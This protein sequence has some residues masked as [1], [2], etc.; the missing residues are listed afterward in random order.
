LEIPFSKDGCNLGVGGDIWDGG[1]DID[2]FD[3]ENGTYWVSDSDSGVT[4]AVASAN[5]FNPIT[6]YYGKDYHLNASTE[7]RYL[8]EN[9]TWLYNRLHMPNGT[10]TDGVTPGNITTTLGWNNET[11]NNG[12]SRTYT[13]VFAIN[14][15]KSTSFDAISEAQEFFYIENNIEF[16]ADAGPD[17][18]VS[19]DDLVFFNG[20]GF[21]NPP[22]HKLT[23]N[24]ATDS[25]LH[26]RQ[27]DP[28][29][30][31]GGGWEGSVT[32]WVTFT[33]E[34]PFWIAKK[35][36]HLG[37]GPTGFE[38]TYFWKMHLT[39]N[40]N[41]HFRAGNGYF[42]ADIYDETLGS[43]IVFN[44]LV[45]YGSTYVN[46][47]LE[48]H[49]IY[50]L[51]VHDTVSDNP[52]M[53]NDLDVMFYINETDILLTPDRESIVHY[54]TVN[55][56]S[57]DGDG[58]GV[59][60]ITFYSRGVQ[61]FYTY[62]LSEL[63]HS[64][65]EI[66][67]GELLYAPNPYKTGITPSEY[68]DTICD[69]VFNYTWDFDDH[70]DSDGDGNF[71]NDAD[72]FGKTPT[73]VYVTEG[74]YEVTV[75]IRGPFGLWDTD[76]CFITVID[77]APPNLYINVSSDS[78]DTVLSWDYPLSLGIDHY[79]IYRSNSQ[80]DF[81]FSLVWK[82]TSF[83]KELNEPDPIPLRCM[84]ND[85]DSANLDNVSCYS[86]QYYYTIRAVNILG[87]ISSTSRTVGKWTRTFNS[88]VSTFSLPLEPLDILSTHDLTKD[89]NADY[90]KYINSTTRTWEKHSL[91]DGPSNNVKMILGEGYE[92]KFLNQTKYTF[93]GMPAAMISY[94]DDTGFSGFDY[95]TE[96]ANLTAFVNPEGNVTLVWSRPKSMGINDSYLIYR[97]PRRDGFFKGSA[98]VVATISYGFEFWTDPNIAQPDTQFYYMIMPVNET[99]KRGASSYSIGIW[100]EEYP[101]K[102]D[103]MGIPLKMENDYSSDW[104]CDNIQNCVGIN[105][106]SENYGMWMW[107]TTR[108]PKGAF[109]PDLV[110]TEGYQ[111]ST[112]SSTKF[113]F[114]GI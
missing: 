92:V 36:G 30:P 41:L 58:A 47:F 113:T 78:N 38:Y 15:S 89:M 71:T 35:E 112:A 11:L 102:Y 26:L 114:I 4:F 67:G 39:G 86:E 3:S 87:K 8:F 97:A 59:T 79:L 72:G 25:A 46:R 9:E 10:A 43:F 5:S 64:E 53:P 69:I 51:Y 63:Y 6:H 37:Q 85:T 105:Y 73:H 57:L 107:H 29:G 108:M 16:V 24:Y 65:T 45:D 95:K 2:G 99:G 98:L 52:T 68:N 19:V 27:S 90:I 33:S 91:F 101:D 106:Y 54:V 100:T 60:N 13:F 48:K 83:D 75:K 111:I 14:D 55:P 12:E 80:T 74:I 21:L 94:D 23:V 66:T 18:T 20:S 109:D 104:F 49:H 28:V 1:D 70:V 22:F 93:C 50:R 44:L 61:E 81:N 76:S 110:M 77:I 42:Y 32:E 40:F 62:Y 56:L 17:Q 84:W 96:A 82:N 7:Y 31:G 88:G 34:S 103:T